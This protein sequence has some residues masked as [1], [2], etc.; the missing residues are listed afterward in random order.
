MNP[1]ATP[2]G[3]NYQVFAFIG[4]E[5]Q[6]VQEKEIYRDP[7]GINPFNERA[8]SMR[9][10][11]DINRIYLSK[12]GELKTSSNAISH[13][14]RMLT[15]KATGQAAIKESIRAFVGSDKGALVDKLMTNFNQA[16]SDR[17]RVGMIPGL[18]GQKVIKGH[19]KVGCL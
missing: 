4:K 1:I 8:D 9:G 11:L 6:R 13:G 10:K 12:D 16:L 5:E 18:P 17:E 3:G 19:E 14:W 2:G 7:N 15:G